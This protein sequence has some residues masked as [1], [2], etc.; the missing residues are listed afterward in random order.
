MTYAITNS[1]SDLFLSDDTKSPDGYVM[2][3]GY[4]FG[5][6]K[7]SSG[8]V[9]TWASLWEAESTAELVGGKVVTAPKSNGYCWTWDEV[10]S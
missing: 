6:V 4:T 10:Q 1:N 2:G 8:K 5:L 3:R 7:A 9:R